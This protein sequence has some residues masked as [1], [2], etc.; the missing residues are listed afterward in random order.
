MQQAVE[1]W[2][3]GARSPYQKGLLAL[4]H[5]DYETASNLLHE[6]NSSSNTNTQQMMAEAFAQFKRADYADSARLLQALIAIHPQDEHFTRAL[7]VVRNSSQRP[8]PP[9]GLKGSVSPR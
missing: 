9:S 3:R 8:A 4:Y 5:D 1:D 6:A 7:T 2:S